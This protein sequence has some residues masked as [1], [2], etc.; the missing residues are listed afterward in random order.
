[1]DVPFSNCPYHSLAPCNPLRPKHPRFFVASKSDNI[2]SKPF[3]L[4][5]SRFF[6]VVELRS[7]HTHH[8]CSWANIV[9]NDTQYLVPGLLSMATFK[10]FC[11]DRA[12]IEWVVKLRTPIIA[13]GSKSHANAYG[14][15]S[16]SILLVY[17]LM[18]PYSPSVK[19]QQVRPGIC[20][21][22]VMPYFFAL[23]LFTFSLWHMVS[24]YSL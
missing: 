13:N 5:Y 2:V 8:F 6:L 12:S 17:P 19:F 20:P 16:T 7:I 15:V 22:M 11:Y 4:S 18:T 14:K 3:L 9:W 24:S 23:P 10:P 1:V 21:L